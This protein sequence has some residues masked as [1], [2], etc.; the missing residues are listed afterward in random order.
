MLFPIHKII[1]F[2]HSYLIFPG[3]RNLSFLL[4]NTTYQN[5]SLVNLE[6][7]GVGDKALHC[8]TDL[9]HCCN[10]LHGE[11]SL[12]NWLY[13]NGTA[14]PSNR[15]WDFHKG[16]GFMVVLMHRRRGGVNGIYHCRIPDAMNVFQTIYIGVY[17]TSTGE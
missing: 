13:P 1:T 17:N 2:V 9:T 8:K 12:G 16:R 6:D 3:G 10:N 7:I 15:K 14:V 5:N 4:S 11:T